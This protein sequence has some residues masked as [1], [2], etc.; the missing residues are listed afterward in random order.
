[1][2]IIYSVYEIS[3]VIGGVAFQIGFSGLAV[4]FDQILFLDHPFVREE[5]YLSRFGF[6]ECRGE[7]PLGVILPAVNYSVQIYPF[8]TWMLIDPSDAI[9]AYDLCMECLVVLPEDGFSRL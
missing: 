5:L 9:A 1:M 3:Q 6:V 7:W 8:Q 4:Q 2:E